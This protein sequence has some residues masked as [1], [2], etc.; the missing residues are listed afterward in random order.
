MIFIILASWGIAFFVYCFM[1]PANRLASKYFDTTQ[2]KIIQE[3]ITLIVFGFFSV[4]YL[5]ESFKWNHAVSFILILGA[6]F[7]GFKKF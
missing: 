1:I 5:N 7:F 3:A 4:F 6:V 2:L